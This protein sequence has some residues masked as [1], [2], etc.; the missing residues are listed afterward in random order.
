VTRALVL[1][2]T[3]IFWAY[4]M[5]EMLQREIVPYFEYQASP[6]YRT[7]LRERAQRELVRRTIRIGTEHIGEAV[8]VIY[9]GPGGGTHQFTDLKLSLRGMLPMLRLDQKLPQALDKISIQTRV[10]IDVAFQLESFSSSGDLLVPVQIEGRRQGDVVQITY[11][12]DR[13]RGSVELPFD[14]LSM[15]AGL[16]SPMEGVGKP[17]LGK[18]WKIQT[19]DVE[20]WSAKPRMTTVFAQIV[21]REYMDHK[22]KKVL[23]FRIDVRRKLDDGRPLSQVWVDDQGEVIV[24]QMDVLGRIPCTIE[25]E[26]KRSLTAGEVSEWV[27]PKR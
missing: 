22:G 3:G 21:E 11:Q 6:S 14:K 17:A 5:S 9:P 16:S 4:M 15:L 2:V 10:F 27:S 1:A 26:E 8:T 12:I 20:L 19:L 13:V 24:E 25:L 18:R 23:A 7:M